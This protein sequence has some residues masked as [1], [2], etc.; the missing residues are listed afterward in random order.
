MSQ[1]SG[2]KRVRVYVDVRE[3]RSPVPGLLRSLGVQVIVKQL[4]M[5]DYLV[6]DSIVVERKAGWDFAR[7]LFD[8]R[9]FEQASRLASHY[10][11]VY[12][13]VEGRLVPGRYRGRERS[14]Y[15]AVAA[16]ESEYGVRVL[17]SH[18]PQGTAYLIES[19]ARLSSRGGGQRVVIHKKPR[20]SS[21]EEWQLYI[22]QAFPG[23]GRKTAEKILERFGS[24]ER[25]F[26]AS[27]A[28]ISKVEGLGD[29]RAEEIKRILVSPY[30]RRQG[31]GKPRSLEDFYS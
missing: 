14:L 22:L 4:P 31:E 23:I 13:I 12:I 7:S 18:D 9:L 24:L 11:R 30:R 16:L 8:G 2:E 5:G 19:L 29:R 17:N 6:S 26:T 27:K 3:E 10:D 25:F 15:A 28:E 21:V 20:L 1:G